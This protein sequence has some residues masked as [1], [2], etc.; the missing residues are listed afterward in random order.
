MEDEHPQDDGNDGQRDQRDEESQPATGFKVFDRRFWTLDDEQLAAADEKPRVPTYV[1]QLEAK[2]A[3]KDK[4]LKEYIA[5]YK[6]EVVEELEQ[7]KRRLENDAAQQRKQ[8]V[9]ELVTPMIEVLEVLE[10]SVIAAQ[11]ASNVE[12]VRDGVRMVQLLMVQKLEAMGLSRI[13]TTGCPFDPAVHEAVA[14]VPAQDATQDNTVAAEL[15]AGFSYEGRV[16]R[17][18]KVQVAKVQR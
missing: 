12:A 8:L 2:V 3:E 16:F 14:V 17:P 9:G 18:A 15:C 10:R 1:A 7:T 5:A 11:T 4:L 13:A 6:K